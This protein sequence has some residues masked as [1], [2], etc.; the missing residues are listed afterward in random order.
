MFSKEKSKELRQEF[1]TSFGKNFPRKWVLYNTKIK[2]LELKFT[3][4]T[5]F[6]QVSL[7]VV[8]DDAV[9]RAFYF[10]KITALQN[11]L[12]TQYLSDAIFEDEYV[13]PEGKTVSKVYVQV[14]EVSIHSTADWNQV[15]IFLYEKMDLLE[16]F[17][18]E[19]KD[20]LEE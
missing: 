8:S 18:L 9:I 3:F 15:Q 16:T 14:G 17:F 13:L 20:F 5:K 11:I 2:D 6:A 4:T 10:E 12:L 7:D 19:Y 1:W